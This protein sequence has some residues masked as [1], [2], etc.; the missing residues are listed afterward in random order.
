MEIVTAIGVD[1][2]SRIHV[3]AA[4]DPQGRVL[5]EHAITAGVQE[6]EEFVAWVQAFAAPQQVAVEG[7]EGYGR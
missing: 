3:A 6:L 2:H 1:A 4:V 7:A 5:A